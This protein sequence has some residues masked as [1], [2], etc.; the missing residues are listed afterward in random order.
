MICEQHRVL[1]LQQASPLLLSAGSIDTVCKV[2]NAISIHYWHS[3]SG[4]LKLRKVKLTSELE[5]VVS[6]QL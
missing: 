4:I 3:C 2:H 5:G 1:S 6:I